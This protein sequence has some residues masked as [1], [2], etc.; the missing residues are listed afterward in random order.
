VGGIPDADSAMP[1]RVRH[2]V[3]TTPALVKF[4]AHPEKTTMASLLL[5]WL[6]VCAISADV[7]IAAPES[8]MFQ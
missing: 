2:E 1:S 5:G 6:A 7:F 4:Q 8:S 3:K